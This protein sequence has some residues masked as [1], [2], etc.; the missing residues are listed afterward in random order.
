MKQAWTIETATRLL[1]EQLTQWGWHLHHEQ[2]DLLKQYASLL[3]NHKAANVIGTK[4][5]PRIILD[6]VLDSLS[7]LSLEDKSLRGTLIDVGS[8]GGLPGIPLAIASTGLS[9]TLLESI[10]KK[11]EFLR[12]ARD[13]LHLS[14]VNVSNQRAEE[15][16]REAGFRHSYDVSVTRALAALP[17][18]VEYC[19]PFVREGGW[20]LAMKG[21]LE[22]DELVVGEKAARRLGAELY[23]VARVRLLAELE[24]KHRQIVVFRKTGPTPTGYP[25]RVGLAKKR[26]LGT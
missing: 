13:V 20:I 15:A 18:V 4:E 21:R 10:E 6:H 1:G 11:V 16:G 23:E 3:A 5:V 2:C 14:N 24:Q 17:V 22:H 9:V 25:R 7:C 26:P 12:Q 19:A 8:G